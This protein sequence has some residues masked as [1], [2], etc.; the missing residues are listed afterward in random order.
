MKGYDEMKL[1]EKESDLDSEIARLAMLII[2]H[3]ELGKF[4]G[5]DVAIFEIVRRYG[6][7][8]DWVNLDYVK[9]RLEILIHPHIETIQV[10]A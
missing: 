4:F 7:I 5:P 9:K 6:L 8:F 1:L 3:S 2:R 10:A